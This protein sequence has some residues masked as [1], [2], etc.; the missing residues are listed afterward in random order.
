MWK[1]IW[2]ALVAPAFA[3]ASGGGGGEAM[4][5]VVDSRRFSGAKAL[6]ANIYNE[7]HLWLALLTILSIPTLGLLMGKITDMF[8]VA[9]G[10]NLKSR[11]MAED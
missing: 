3:L 5:L 10:I 2:L 9:I 7:S 11:V 8:L 1:S 6:W 4:I